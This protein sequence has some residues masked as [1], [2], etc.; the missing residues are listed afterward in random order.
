[1]GEQ[2]HVFGYPGS[3]RAL[4]ANRGLSFSQW[5]HD[6]L[7]RDGFRL[8]S[9]KDL[10]PNLHWPRYVTMALE[11]ETYTEKD[12]EPTKPTKRIQKPTQKRTGNN[13]SNTEP[14]KLWWQ[15]QQSER[16]QSTNGWESK[17]IAEILNIFEVKLLSIVSQIKWV[18]FCGEKNRSDHL[19][20]I[21]LHSA[22]LFECDN[23]KIH[24]NVNIDS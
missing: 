19:L 10:P 2:P 15:P 11:T 5:G 20:L 17:H 9:P 13:R 8:L 1:M 12:T 4:A 7:L 23:F 24:L 18:R 6:T 16:Q 21:R 22:L 3:W 14:R